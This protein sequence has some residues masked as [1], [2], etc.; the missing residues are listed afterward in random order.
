MLFGCFVIGEWTA[1]KMQCVDKFVNLIFFIKY[2]FIDI[3]EFLINKYRL[4][5]FLL[6]YKFWY[7]FFILT[8]DSCYSKCSRYEI[9]SVV[10]MRYECLR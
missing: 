7:N 9:R 2:I 8:Y 10:D 4:R 6:I 1:V 5:I 3:I